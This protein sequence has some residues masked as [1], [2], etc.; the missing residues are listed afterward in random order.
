MCVELKSQANKQL[1]HGNTKMTSMIQKSESFSGTMAD[2]YFWL[3]SSNAVLVKND[4]VFKTYRGF[5][6][7]DNGRKVVLFVQSTEHCTDGIVKW[8]QFIGH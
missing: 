6:Y 1:T 7:D 5:E 8:R 2:Y 3:R 4:G